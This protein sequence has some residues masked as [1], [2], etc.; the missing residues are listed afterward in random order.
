MPYKAR[1]PRK[2]HPPPCVGKLGLI[3]GGPVGRVT[4]GRATVPDSLLLD[5]SAGVLI[6]GLGIAAV[7]DLRAREVPDHLWVGLAIVGSVLGALGI[8][9]EGWI[10]LL[11]WL[12][13]SG[14][15]L[16]H[17]VPWDAAFGGTA[18]ADW[19]ELVAYIVVLGIV[20]ISVVRIGL[21]SSEVPVGVVAVVVSVL[22]ARA[23]FEAGVLFGGADAKAVMV[24]GLMVPLFPTSVLA[25]PAAVQPVTS[26]LPFAV[27]LLVDAALLSVAAPLA[28]AV[29][30]AS[31]GEFHLRGGFTTCTIRVA[32]LPKRWVWVRDPSFPVDRAEEEAIETSAE[33]RRWRERTAVELS[34][35][36]VQRVRVG[37][38]LPFVVFLF[39]GAIFAVVAGN[40][41]LDLL[42]AL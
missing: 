36:G 5:L 23:L 35:R 20:G 26:V 29:L 10:P 24:A 33:D 19:V 28:L 31:R 2:A 42:V 12:L 3:K 4:G 37:P 17:L 18:R 39:L 41:V 11:L 40:L 8:A 15:V 14:F 16:E 1:S 38:Q 6:A 7:L 21:G 34:K 9:P 22:F 32:D 30:N 27:D 25:I 13:A